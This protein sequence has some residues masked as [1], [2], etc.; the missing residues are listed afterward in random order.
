VVISKIS[1]SIRPSAE[2]WE[3]EFMKGGEKAED[4][5]SLSNTKG[6]REDISSSKRGTKSESSSQSNTP[7]GRDKGKK[8]KKKKKK[9]GHKQEEPGSEA[10]IF[11]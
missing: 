10:K 4:S 5:L 9:P 6:G 8:K 7:Y 11:R 1:T 3:R 2:K